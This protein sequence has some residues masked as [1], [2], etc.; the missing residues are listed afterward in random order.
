M[1]KRKNESYWAT[2]IK[3]YE[4]QAGKETQVAF[5]R[6]K[7]IKLTTFQKR[8]YRARQRRAGGRGAMRFVEVKA[9][10][11]SAD[12]GMVEI[13]IGGGRFTV[14]FR[15]ETNAEKIAEVV[16]AVATRVEC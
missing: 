5:A 8:L 6:R 4:R 9:G 3:E 2:L 15:G 11:A 16:S 13:D 10:P 7:A 12:R 1:A 14:R